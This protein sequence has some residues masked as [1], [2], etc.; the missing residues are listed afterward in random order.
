MGC[1][2]KAGT[3]VGRLTLVVSLSTHEGGAVTA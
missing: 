1:A 2:V 3:W